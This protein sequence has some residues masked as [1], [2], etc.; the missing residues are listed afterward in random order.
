MSNATKTEVTPIV[1]EKHKTTTAKK[2][3]AKK[4]PAKKATR[5]PAAKKT[6]AKKTGRPT[7]SAATPAQVK[8]LTD[9]QAAV[10]AAEKALEDAKATR[11]KV[12]LASV[13]LGG[14]EVGRILGIRAG[15]ARRLLNDAQGIP[16]KR[17][18]KTK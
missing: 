4:A 9:S 3:T 2:T 15:Q 12:L 1:K 10:D 6:T 17:A 5:K 16:R 8:S 7:K 18:R 11:A 14:S 13:E